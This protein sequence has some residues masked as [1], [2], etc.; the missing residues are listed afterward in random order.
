MRR[1]NV[2]SAVA[3]QPDDPV[4]FAYLQS[5]AFGDVGLEAELLHLF[6]DQARRLVPTLPERASLDQANTIHLLK[7]SARAVGASTIA[8]ALETYEAAQPNER[9]SD[10]PLFIALVAA[11]AA[12]AVA[13][14]ERLAVI[15]AGSV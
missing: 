11:L 4:N 7:G 9:G 2:A 10:A 8:A 12:G 15:A 3:R 1:D 13:I 5:Q 14:E 6:L